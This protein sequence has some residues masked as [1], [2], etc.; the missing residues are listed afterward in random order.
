MTKPALSSLGV[1]AIVAAA[2]GVSGSA[3]A[4][5]NNGVPCSSAP[6]PPRGHVL[7]KVEKVE[8]N[9]AVTLRLLHHEGGKLAPKVGNAAYLLKCNGYRFGGPGDVKL[10]TVSGM[11]ATTAIAA[12]REQILGHYVA[13]DTG[14]DSQPPLREGEVRPPSGY[15]NAQIVALDIRNSK[16]SIVFNRGYGDGVFPGAKGYVIDDKGAPLSGGSFTVEEATS[17]HAVRAFV[18]LTRGVVE[19]NLAVYVEASSRRCTAPNPVLPAG[20]ELAQVLQG[21]APP[22][23]W[24]ALDLPTSRSSWPHFTVATGTSHGVLPPVKAFFI[25]GRGMGVLH[26]ATVSEVKANTTVFTVF[27][28]NPSALKDAP[29]RLI[30]SVGKC[31]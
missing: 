23:G 5:S 22:Q 11:N 30:A 4:Q 9:G 24:V 7:A 6:T 13:I 25:I 3:T 29:L 27:G 26:P 18:G 28:E 8:T 31:N 12:P 1:A 16:T 19:K 20:V 2:L 10:D 21:G 15:V 14:Y 17:E